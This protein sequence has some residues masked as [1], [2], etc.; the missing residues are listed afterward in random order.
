MAKMKNKTQANMEN[1]IQ[2]AEFADLLYSVYMD[3]NESLSPQEQ[4]LLL[5]NFC[6]AV[7]NKN[8]YVSN[9]D[10]H[11][12]FI[13][14]DTRRSD[15]SAQTSK[16]TKVVTISEDFLRKA[17]IK[18]EI[19]LSEVFYVLG[20]ERRHIS[21]INALK[22]VP[23]KHFNRLTDD[24]KKKVKNMI[25]DLNEQEIT[26]DAV[27]FV[28]KI[29]EKQLGKDS[30]EFKNLSKEEKKKVCEKFASDQ[31]FKFAHEEDAR[32]TGYEF[33]NHMIDCI[34]AD[35]IMD[36]VVKR[37]I[38]EER[39][40]ITRLEQQDE[41]LL[42]IENTGRSSVNEA[43]ENV[44]I[45]ELAETVSG[46]NSQIS[47][48]MES[49]EFKDKYGQYSSNVMANVKSNLKE[50]LHCAVEYISNQRI[51]NM[52]INDHVNC[53][54]TSL[55]TG[56]TYGL[57]H[58]AKQLKNR[59]DYTPGKQKEVN[60]NIAKMFAYGDLHYDVFNFDFLEIGDVGTLSNTI[61]NLIKQ[62]KLATAHRLYDS[63]K[64]GLEI[65][66][67][68]DKNVSKT[69]LQ[70]FEDINKTLLSSTD[71]Y[72]ERVQESG[73]YSKEE[74]SIIC[75]S[76]G[77][78][79]KRR[80]KIHNLYDL[81]SMTDDEEKNYLTGV[82]GENF[83]RSLFN[84]PDEFELRLQLKREENRR[85]REGEANKRIN[86]GMLLKEKLGE[87]NEVQL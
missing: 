4:G 51:K 50:S 57:T 3:G 65:R 76:L 47:L 60:S 46:L 39:E 58:L 56:Y 59:P 24:N 29:L 81:Q 14:G 78:D 85:K 64:T 13:I 53:M 23:Q 52:S 27:A 61:Q 12:Y 2:R 33:A 19:P 77:V 68:L 69:D 34:T 36:K 7:L 72:I 71:K 37:H 25:H 79:E 35:N 32:K 5:Y 22:D 6:D 75:A 49:E 11:A 1:D 86:D 43:I 41:E 82:Y 15:A 10:E 40:H 26:D 18:K 31:Y 16:Q 74:L 21:Q 45:E 38:E 8:P 73:K 28:F 30:S 66:N 17:L 42:A 20:H 67:L 9:S 54:Y 44:S 55:A 63:A 84:K 48:L 70:K 80:E 87:T 83:T 62:N